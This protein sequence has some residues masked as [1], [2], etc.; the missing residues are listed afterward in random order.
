MISDDFTYCRAVR[1]PFRS[2]F[3]HGL[4]ERTEVDRVGLPNLANHLV[5]LL[6]HLLCLSCRFRMDRSMSAAMP[7][8]LMRK[9]SAKRDQKALV[10]MDKT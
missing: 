7:A 5:N 9:A 8:I 1:P 2:N 10:K 3:E 4:L 6:E